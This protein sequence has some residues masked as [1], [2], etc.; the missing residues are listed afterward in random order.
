MS[1]SMTILDG[2]GDSTIAWTEDQDEQMRNFIQK[3]MDDGWSFFIVKPHLGGML[4]PK[5][6]KIKKISE[7]KED[8]RA[9]SL[10]DEDFAQLIQAGLGI[11]SKPAGEIETTGR[12]KTAAEAARTSTV[13]VKPKRGG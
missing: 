10:R 2:S 9:V 1:R 11:G 12:A 3:K 4:P 8:D 6:V 7:L 5:K 13:A